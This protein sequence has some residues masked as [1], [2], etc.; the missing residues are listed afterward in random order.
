MTQQTPTR[1]ARTPQNVTTGAVAA[2]LAAVVLAN[3]VTAHAGLVVLAFTAGT[4]IAGVTFALRDT[5]QDAG[6]RWR[7]VAVIV[8]G[9]AISA[10]L[11]PRLAL[12]SGI[13][14]LLSE[15][16]DWGIYTPLRGRGYYRAALT[17]NV[18][19]AVVDTVVFLWLAGF[20]LTGPAVTGQ[21]IVKVTMSTLVMFWTRRAVPR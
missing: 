8:A 9:A 3:L 14:F 19:G 20:A 2:F 11:T 10:L 15:L 6:G 1:P 18:A 13:A 4:P 5:I 16:A 21:L 7:I 17:S 12:A